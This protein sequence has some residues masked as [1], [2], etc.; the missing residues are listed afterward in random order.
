M[1][2]Y[3]QIIII[4]I[5]VLGGQIMDKKRTFEERIGELENRMDAVEIRVGDTEEFQKNISKA[6]D[7]LGKKNYSFKDIEERNWMIYCAV[8]YLKWSRKVAAD[9]FNISSQQVGNI[10]NEKSL[11]GY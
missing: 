11:L 9:R 2:W 1:F 5:Q 7:K 8:N 6:L 4:N 10:M 3:K